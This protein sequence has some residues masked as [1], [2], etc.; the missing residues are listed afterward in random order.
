M[1]T[2][3]ERVDIAVIGAGVIGS[4]TA[5]ALAARGASAVL[6]EQFGP[7]HARGSSHGATRIFRL[8]Y[9]D[10]GYVRMAM[11]AQLSWAALEADAGERLLVTTGGLDAGPGAAAC[12]AALAECGSSSTPGWRAAS[13]RPVSRG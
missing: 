6:L 11:A 3:V 1:V 2:A 5:R 7:G 12:A 9:P 8:A 4:A 13:C 10:P